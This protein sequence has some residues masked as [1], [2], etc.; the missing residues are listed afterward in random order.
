MARKPKFKICSCGSILK[1]SNKTGISFHRKRDHVIK[2][3]SYTQEQIDK[4]H[5]KL[6]NEN[7]S[8]R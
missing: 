1:C 2:I 3:D 6:R 4:Y 8:N 7:V 5:E